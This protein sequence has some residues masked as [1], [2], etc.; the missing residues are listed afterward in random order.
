MERRC[1]V[2]LGVNKMKKRILGIFVC[3]LL[4]ITILP[5]TGTVMAGDEENPEIEDEAG[6]AL[7]YLDV[8]SAW[9]YEN[10]DEP[11]YLSCVIG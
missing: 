10:P 6:D 2:S 11:N 8:L 9:F 1:S 3:M 5:M 7:G 4:I